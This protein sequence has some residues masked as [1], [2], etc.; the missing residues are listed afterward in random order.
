MRASRLPSSADGYPAS[1]PGATAEECGTV[2]PDVRARRSRAAAA[3]SAFRRFCR[4][5]LGRS[6]ACLASVPEFAARA[7]IHPDR[8]KRLMDDGTTDRLSADELLRC[9]RAF[10]ELEDGLGGAFLCA[11]L[12][13]YGYA[14]HRVAGDDPDLLG[15][16]AEASAFAAAVCRVE[17]RPD[18][19]TAPDLLERMDRALATMAAARAVV[20]PKVAS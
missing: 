15:S 9:A 12:A 8:L 7:R 13:G 2:V 18:H 20:A 11:L 5:R 3:E 4:K 14:A 1:R 16:A 19:R 6:R 10:D 17:G